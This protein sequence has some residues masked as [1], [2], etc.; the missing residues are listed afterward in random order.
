MRVVL[1]RIFCFDGTG[2]TTIKSFGKFLKKQ[3]KTKK[4]GFYLLFQKL[5]KT[6][7]ITI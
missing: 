4:I 7:V 3:I 6:F 5:S 2:S 1:V